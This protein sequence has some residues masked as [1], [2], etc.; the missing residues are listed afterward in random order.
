MPEYRVFISRKNLDEDGRNADDVAIAEALHKQLTELGINTFLDDISLMEQGRAQYKKAI[1]DALDEAEILIA[2]G[3]SVE[4]LESEWVRYEWDSFFN[5][6]ISGIKPDGQVISLTSNTKPADLPRALRQSQAFSVESD[7][8]DRATNFVVSAL[9]VEPPRLTFDQGRQYKPVDK[10]TL[11]PTA[12]LF[13]DIV[14]TTTM[15]KTHVEET[16]NRII[17]KTIRDW[18]QLTRR[19]YGWVIKVMGDEVMCAFNTAD[20]CIQAAIEVHDEITIGLRGESIKIRLKMGICFNEARRMPKNEVFGDAVN[21]AAR[22]TGIARADQVMLDGGTVAALS[23]DFRK[24]CIK[25]GQTTVKGSEEPFDYY[26]FDLTPPP[27]AIDA[28]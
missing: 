12:I 9:G 28:P 21:I 13:M 24:R 17:G 20:D 6:I 23:E 15:Y 11:M 1:D 14:G 5:D 26:L 22:M 18:F 7:G 27:S 3:S 2:V 25:Q 4:N 8:V 10:P 19:H 16:T